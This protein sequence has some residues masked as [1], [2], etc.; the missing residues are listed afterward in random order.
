MWLLVVPRFMFVFFS[1]VNL[2]Q[3]EEWSNNKVAENQ[4]IWGNPVKK[5]A[6]NDLPRHYVQNTQNQGVTYYV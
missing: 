3:L 4:S 6:K 1:L 2:K 5:P